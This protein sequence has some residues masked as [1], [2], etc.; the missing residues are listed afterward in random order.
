MYKNI[1][2]HVVAIETCF[3]SCNNPGMRSLSNENP[4]ERGVYCLLYIFIIKSH[5]RSIV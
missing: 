2:D 1:T 4:L 5:I 3:Q